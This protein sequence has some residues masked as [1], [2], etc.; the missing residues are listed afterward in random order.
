LVNRRRTARRRPI[1]KDQEMETNPSTRTPRV[2]K[3]VSQERLLGDAA[4]WRRFGAPVPAGGA[5]RPDGTPDYGVF[6]PGSIVWEVLL[7]PAVICFQTA[8]QTNLQ[9]TYK[10]VFA[11][12]RDWDP[13]SRKGRNG[14]LTLFDIFDRAQRNSGIHTPMWLGT[15]DTARRVAKHLYNIHTKVK[16]E[17]I[18]AGEPELGGYD[19][20]GPRD[21]MWAALTE[22]HSMLWVYERMG[23]RE[24]GSPPCRLTPT[25]RDQFV[26]ETAEYCRLFASPEEEIPTSMAELH[27]LYTKYDD[28][29]RRSRTMDTIPLTRQNLYQVGLRTALK[30][31]HIS[32]LRLLAPIAKLNSLPFLLSVYYFPTWGAMS[33]KTRKNKGFGPVRNA[34]AVASLR[35]LRPLI[36]R[37]QRPK[38]E[39]KMMR[40][41]WGPDAMML[42]ESARRL[43]R[44]VKEGTLDVPVGS[45]GLGDR[46]RP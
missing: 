5:T 14:E 46:S 40:L 21:S 1:M 44:K 42:I 15:S 31:I 6:G 36:K 9:F 37:A 18:D 13:I 27:A 38:S 26:A 24:D 39:A 45:V 19:A 16:G 32:Q 22:L 29:F 34:L 7:H 4:R 28:L 3:V 17:T 2:K 25:E 11:G 30:N 10:P 33:G 8:A 20:N 12:I 35:L 23:F 41:L 43:H